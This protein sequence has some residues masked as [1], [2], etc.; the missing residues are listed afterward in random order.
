ML[1][2]AGESEWR[3]VRGGPVRPLRGHARVAAG[4][5][6]GPTGGRGGVIGVGLA[7]A[8]AGW[9]YRR[10]A[11]RLARLAGTVWGWVRRLRAERSRP[12]RLDRWYRVGDGC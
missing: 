12:P 5:R 10:I 8:A 6:P 9:G 11:A 2:A 3:A 4:A 1:R 7:L